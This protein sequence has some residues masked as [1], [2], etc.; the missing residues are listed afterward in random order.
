MVV[1]G[2]SLEIINADCTVE[3]GRQPDLGKA[4]VP[5]SLFEYP[6]KTA[7]SLLWGPSLA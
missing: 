1:Q 7:V 5:G 2:T 6:A 4:P 3:H